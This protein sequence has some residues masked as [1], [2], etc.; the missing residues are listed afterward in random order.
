MKPPLQTN[1]PQEYFYQKLLKS[2]KIC[3]TYWEKFIDRSLLPRF[4]R[5]T[6]YMYV[7]ARVCVCAPSPAKFWIFLPRNG[8]FCVHSDTWLNSSQVTTPVLI[9]LKAW[10]SSDIVTKPCKVVIRLCFSGIGFS[11]CKQNKAYSISYEQILMKFSGAVGCVPE[12]EVIRFWDQ[13]SQLSPGGST[14]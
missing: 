3:Q 8:T 12:E 6:V 10:K 4:L 13:V 14:M 11:V 1:K 2:V 7:C 9:R 5:P